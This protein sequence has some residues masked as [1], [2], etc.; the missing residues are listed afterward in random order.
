MPVDAETKSVLLRCKG[1][2][3]PETLQRAKS[4][5]L[6]LRLAGLVVA[7]LVVVAIAKGFSSVWV[8]VGAVVVG[9]LVAETNALRTRLSQWGTF[10]RYLDWQRIEQDIKDAT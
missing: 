5:A 1:L 7:C 4:I 6:W 10:S 3:Q 9:W 2:S 8:A